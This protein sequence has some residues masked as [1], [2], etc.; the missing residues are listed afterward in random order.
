MCFDEVGRKLSVRLGLGSLEDS[1]AIGSGA[2][3]G[4]NAL[5]ASCKQG[6]CMRQ[7]S[8]FCCHSWE[9]ACS[10]AGSETMDCV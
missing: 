9:M 3:A 10:L 4:F 7:H 1:T 8:N 6:R 5:P 2:C